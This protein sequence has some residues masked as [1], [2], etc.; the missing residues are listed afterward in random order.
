MI[1][2]FDSDNASQFWQFVYAIMFV[3]VPILVIMMATDLAGYFLE[4]IRDVFTFKRFR[5]NRD[6]YTDE[7]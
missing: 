1:S 6:E 3:V 4:V 7:Q 5:K 2:F